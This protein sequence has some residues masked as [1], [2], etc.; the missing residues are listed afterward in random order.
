M[1]RQY[2]KDRD[3]VVIEETRPIS[4]HKNF[5]RFKILEIIK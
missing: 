2:R 4:K 3:K 5:K 1:I